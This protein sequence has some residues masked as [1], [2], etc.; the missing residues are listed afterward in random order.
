MPVLLSF[1]AKVFPVFILNLSISAKSYLIFMDDIFTVNIKKKMRRLLII[2]I[3]LYVFI[4]IN[5]LLFISFI[6]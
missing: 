2:E 3:F 4:F 5:L 6:A 1:G